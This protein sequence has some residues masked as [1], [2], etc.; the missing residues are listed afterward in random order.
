MSLKNFKFNINNLKLT[1]EKLADWGKNNTQNVLP[2]SQAIRKG[3]S[4]STKLNSFNLNYPPA[5]NNKNKKINKHNKNNNDNNKNNNNN[6][7][8]N[9][10][11]NNDSQHS[12]GIEANEK[13]QICATI[14]LS[15][16]NPDFV[17]RDENAIVSVDANVIED[18]SS[19]MEVD[20]DTLHDDLFEG[21]GDEFKDSDFLLESNLKGE[22]NYDIDD[23]DDIDIIDLTRIEANEKLQICATINLS[24]TNPDF[25]NRDEN[26][27]VSV[28][29][30]V[31]E[32]TSSN[33]EVDMDTLHDDLFEGFGDEFKDSDFLL[34]SNLKGEENYDIDDIDDIDIIDLTSC[35][36]N[37]QDDEI[38]IME[39]ES[40]DIKENKNSLSKKNNNNND[41][42][43][44]SSDPLKNNSSVIGQNIK[45][46]SDKSHDFI[47]SLTMGTTIPNKSPTLDKSLRNDNEINE[48]NKIKEINETNEINEINEINNNKINNRKISEIHVGETDHRLPK[49]YS[50]NKFFH[51]PFV[52]KSGVQ[53]NS[54]IIIEMNRT[55]EELE[56]LMKREQD[57]QLQINQELD[58]IERSLEFFD[59]DMKFIQ[60]EMYNLKQQITIE[61]IE[62]FE[63]YKIAALTEITYAEMTN[64]EMKDK[65]LTNKEMNDIEMR[66]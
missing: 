51:S 45:K 48:I 26:A 36:N 40:F 32:D 59:D 2:F 9:N 35:N 41:D 42:D 1:P 20:M 21:F 5:N 14:N 13:L 55:L 38:F 43:K 30:N 18:T 53:E 34:E 50:K 8:N 6:N 3:S 63:K 23:I 25:V 44:D 64:E 22:E 17:N 57:S 31:I 60:S 47:E 49:E 12:Q 27:I 58:F 4:T 62:Q 7:N 61:I 39:K 10:N 16:T 46:F 29:A 11:D 33:M 56:S 52:Y 37:I 28:D 15:P 65:E 19:N 24:P 66:K 54:K